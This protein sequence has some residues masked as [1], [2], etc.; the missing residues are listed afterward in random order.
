MAEILS[1]VKTYFDTLDQRFVPSAAKGVDAVI[2]WEIA[3][4]EGGDFHAIVKDDAVAVETGKHAS[5]S[6]TIS[7]SDENYLKLLNGKLN[8]AMA[9]MT[10]KMKVNG[11][12]KLARKMQQMFPV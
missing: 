10:R 6:V 11:N 1:S 5:P 3:G 7:I 4:P 8:G 2:Q 12:I 9:V